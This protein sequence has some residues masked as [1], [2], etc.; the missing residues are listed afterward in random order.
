MVDRDALD[1]A[2]PALYEE[3]RRIAHGHLRREQ[4]GHTL[5]TTSLVHE[6]YLRLVG[7]EAIDWTSRSHFLGMASRAMR[8]VL[9]DYARWRKRRKRSGEPDVVNIDAPVQL[10][11]AHLDDLLLLDAS[12]LRLERMQPR[13]CRVVECRFFAGMTNEETAE[14]LQIS[15]ATVKRDWA[16]ARA[17]L[18]AEL[19]AA[20]VATDPQRAQG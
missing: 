10:P 4:S 20:G 15:V 16:V 19:H 8:R 9:I 1:H 17:W 11:I 5:N 7:L 12:L 2:L 18:N 13:Q 3:L 14:S 6:A